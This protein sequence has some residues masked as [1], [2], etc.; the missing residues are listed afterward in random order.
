MHFWPEDDTF[1]R[2]LHMTGWSREVLGERRRREGSGEGEGA[3]A[4]EGQLGRGGRPDGQGMGRG[5]D[6]GGWGVGGL[7]I[8]SF[9]TNKRRLLYLYRRSLFI[10]QIFLSTKINFQNSSK[11]KD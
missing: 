5:T 2:D 11:V 10:Y 6:D 9:R 1:V 8:S 4:A 7:R 3:E